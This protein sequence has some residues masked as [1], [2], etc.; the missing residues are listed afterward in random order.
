[1]AGSELRTL[2]RGRRGLCPCS[3]TGRASAVCGSGRRNIR[4]DHVPRSH[5][6][7]HGLRR[8]RP[9]TI[10][11]H[12][13]D[14]PRA[15]DLKGIIASAL[16]DHAIPVPIVRGRRGG[17]DPVSGLECLGMSDTAAEEQ[18]RAN[19]DFRFHSLLPRRDWRRAWRKAGI[20]SNSK[21]APRAQAHRVTSCRRQPRSGDRFSI[22]RRG[23]GNAGR[24]RHRN[25]SGSL[26]DLGANGAIFAR[27]RAAGPD[28]SHPRGARTRIVE[29]KGVRRIMG[30]ISAPPL[31]PIDRRD[32]KGGI[33][34][35][36]RD[37]RRY[38]AAMPPAPLP[39]DTR[40]PEQSTG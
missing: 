1:M 34:T 18:P 38:A 28:V 19:E 4:N 26:H 29:E 13:P 36:A 7:G 22:P 16:F 9:D 23:S 6:I 27:H 12:P 15:F 33:V 2:L 20:G 8:R 14:R 39:S 40:T 25:A 5:G 35:L 30:E 17:V 32:R 37:C 3:T 24:E 21:T 11:R 31:R 10:R